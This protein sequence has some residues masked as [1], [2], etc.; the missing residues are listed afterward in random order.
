MRLSLAFLISTFFPI[1]VAA[2]YKSVDS[3]AT[4]AFDRMPPVVV[5]DV[6]AGNCGANAGVNP[7]AAYCTSQ[8]TIYL[9]ELA[10]NLPETPYLIAHLYGHAAQV[11]HG[12]A[13][14]AFAA[15]RSRPNEE[16]AL[17]GMVTRQVECLA[18]MYMAL[19]GLNDLSLMDWLNDE[20]FTGSHW[21]RNPLSRGPQVSI[22]L[23]ARDEWFQIGQKA[24]HPSACS[25][26]EMNAELLVNAYKN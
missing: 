11:R 3:A 19:A 26:I 16:A 6:I 13:D 25:V 15:I 21:S 5:V 1:C 4:S 12:V 20:P 24:V 23:A 18:G 7:K 22:G 2:D 10:S 17:R 8:N 14:V 9:S